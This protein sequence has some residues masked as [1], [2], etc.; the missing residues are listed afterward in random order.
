M[1][2]SFSEV[3]AELPTLSVAE[4]QA[5]VQRAIEL[6]DCGLSPEQDALIDQR[7]AE[8]RS[9]PSTAISMEEMKKRLR[10]R[11]Y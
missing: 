11:N 1:R 3:L 4:R 8:H 6:D 2:M 7:L 9:D 5:V 10:S